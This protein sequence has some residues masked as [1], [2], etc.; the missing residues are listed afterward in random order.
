M[1][2]L[3][4]IEPA[5]TNWK[6]QKIIICGVQ[7]LGKGT[8][9]STF[10]KPILVRTEDGAGALSIPTFPD[11]VEDFAG[12]EAAINTLHQEHNFKTL[13][14]D[15]LDWMEPVIWA[16]QIEEEPLTEKDKPVIDIESYGYG[17]GFIKALAWWR[18]IMGGFNSLRFNKNM[19]IVL[20]SH[21]E[22]K[23]YDP[24]DSDPYDRYQIKLHKLAAALW[25]EWADMVL[26]CNYKTHTRKAEV[27]FD[28]K[29]VRG[30]GAGERVIFTEERP[31]YLAKN[32]WGLPPEIYIG[33]DKTWAAFHE[34]LSLCTEGRYP[35]LSN[36]EPVKP[37]KK[38]GEKK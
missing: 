38:K 25:Q 29:I 33:Q 3:D 10:E 18:Y 28:K 27:G 1:F 37:S 31:A 23:R 21:T 19:E 6:P 15:S 24:P 9:G 20:I 30:V 5:N 34:A 11:M 35:V 14:I 7:G 32:R 12:M 26:F 4:S 2:S 22:I 36:I 16:K 17:K 8:F 13:L